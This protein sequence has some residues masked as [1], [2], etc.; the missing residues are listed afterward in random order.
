[1]T[2]SLSQLL[3]HRHAQ[4][5]PAR[6]QRAKRMLSIGLNMLID[7]TSP[8][9]NDAYTLARSNVKDRLRPAW[10]GLE[11]E[12]ENCADVRRRRVETLGPREKH[13][14]VV[15]Q[16]KLPQSAAHHLSRSWMGWQR[17]SAERTGG[18]AVG[19]IPHARAALNAG[20]G[21]RLERSKLASA[22]RTATISRAEPPAGA[23]Q[24]V[25]AA[26]ERATVQTHRGGAGLTWG[27][28]GRA[29]A[30]GLARML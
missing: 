22:R 26:G 15:A 17:V 7:W 18:I 1:M 9:A 30:R 28:G 8:S 5:V 11:L 4:D 16:I 13:H 19:L 10:V 20:R 23:P 29:E 14:N 27:E 21:C 12:R 2:L 24:Q 6:P 25:R 3:R